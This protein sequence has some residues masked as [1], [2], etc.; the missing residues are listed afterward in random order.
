MP[1]TPGLRPQGKTEH[2]ETRRSNRR[3]L[4]QGIFDEGPISRADLARSTGLGRATVSDIATDLLA[5]GLIVESGRGQSTGGKPP[6][7]VE[8]NPDGRFTVAVDLARHP[9][10][11]ALLDLRGRIVARAIGKTITP[12]RRDALD[13]IHRVV[14]RLVGDATAPA[15]GIGVGVPGVVDR[16]GL[17]VASEQLGWSDAPLREELEE[18]YGIPVHLASD[19]EAAAVAEVGRTGSDPSGRMLYVKVDDRIAVAFVT[20]DRLN[21]TPR[22]G[23]DLTHLRVPGWKDDCGCGRRGCLGCRVSMIRILGPDYLEMSTEA[24]NRL[25]VETTPRVGRAAVYLGAAIAPIVAAVDA[26]QVVIGG[27]MAG[28]P[29]VPEQVSAGISKHLEWCPQVSATQLGESAVV[30]GAAAMVLS[31]E[32]GVVWG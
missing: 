3:L 14:A 13:E 17:V 23:G 8:L 20:A 28:W 5:E 2:E 29:A 31:G 6:T 15:L 25:A 19:V 27:E 10:E 7:L 18:V 22:H 30:L 1:R 26:D 11:A 12:Q 32:L 21:R 16:S 24:R 9:I 4:L